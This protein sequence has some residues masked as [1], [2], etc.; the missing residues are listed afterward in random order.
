MGHLKQGMGVLTV[1]VACCPLLSQSDL[2][3]N[4]IGKRST[5]SFALKTILLCPPPMKWVPALLNPWT[6]TEL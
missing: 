6:L 3:S 2:L 4:T 1:F 5:V